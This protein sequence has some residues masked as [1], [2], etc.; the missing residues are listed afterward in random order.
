MGFY[1]HVG[2][3]LPGSVSAGQEVQ[4]DG[5]LRILVRGKV[6]KKMKKGGKQHGPNNRK[7][8]KHM[9]NKHGNILDT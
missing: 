4:E 6:G 5:E 3:N 1:G 2:L 7:M 8:G 9:N